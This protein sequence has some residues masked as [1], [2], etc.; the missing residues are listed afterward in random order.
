M[1]RDQLDSLLVFQICHGTRF[2]DR[3]GRI[4]RPRRKI[5]KNT[6]L[7]FGLDLTLQDQPRKIKQEFTMIL[8]GL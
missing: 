4:Q 1:H 5:G 8:A 6:I 3:R 7:S 2:K